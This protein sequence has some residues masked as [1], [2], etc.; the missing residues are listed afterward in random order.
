MQLARIYRKKE[1]HKKAVEILKEG[2][3]MIKKL[4]IVKDAKM[5]EKL[6]LSL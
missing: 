5:L 2:H 1:D 4:G 3:E 6:Y